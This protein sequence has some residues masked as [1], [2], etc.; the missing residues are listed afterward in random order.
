MIHFIQNIFNRIMLCGYNVW[1][2][3]ICCFFYIYHKFFI[4]LHISLDEEDK[5]FFF[6]DK[7]GLSKQALNNLTDK[8]ELDYFNYTGKYD[9]LNNLMVWFFKTRYK[10][11]TIKFSIKNYIPKKSKIDFIHTPSICLTIY[12]LHEFVNA[13]GEVSMKNSFIQR[14]E[15]NNK[16]AWKDFNTFWNANQYSICIYNNEDECY[17][18]IMLYL[19]IQYTYH[20]Y[21][22][23]EYPKFIQATIFKLGL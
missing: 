8:F 23:K 2:C 7:Y 6:N 22:E 16:T 10:D 5:L 21:I 1:T 15:Y 14:Y 18:K 20:H 4:P 17:Y 3:I 19:L 12:K 13:F 11:I 9:H